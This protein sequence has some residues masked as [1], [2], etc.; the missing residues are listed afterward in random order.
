MGMAGGTTG[1]IGGAAPGVEDIEKMTRDALLDLWPKVMGGPVPRGMSQGMLRRFLAFE[2]QAQAG[3]GLGKAE[4]A[5]IARLASGSAHARA[6]RLAQG[7]RF[8]REWNGVT[9]VVERSEAG[10]LWNGEVHAS[11]SA[12]AKAI[13]GAH[14]SGPRFFGVKAA[15]RSVAKNGVVAKSTTKRRVADI[16]DI[17]TPKGWRYIV[18]Y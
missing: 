9:H 14:W 5:E 8:L 1:S 10:Y 4:R 15:A 18:L 2:V 6:D 3:G 7:S 16:S 11:L 13:T 12:M 17:L